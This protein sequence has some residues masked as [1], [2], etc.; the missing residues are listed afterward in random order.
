MSFLSDSENE[1][2][3]LTE[4][5]EFLNHNGLSMVAKEGLKKCKV[6]RQRRTKARVKDLTVTTMAIVEVAP[7]QSNSKLSLRTTLC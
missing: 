7:N 2:E 3:S 5:Q 6:T 4:V 1:D